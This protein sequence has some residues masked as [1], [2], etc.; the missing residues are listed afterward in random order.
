M[1]FEAVLHL[2]CVQIVVQYPISIIYSNTPPPPPP[3]PPRPPVWGINVVKNYCLK[4][5]KNPEDKN[6]NPSSE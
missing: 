5:E 1:Q 4:E 3:A 2:F 6:R